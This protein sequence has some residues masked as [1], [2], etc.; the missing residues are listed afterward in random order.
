[1]RVV[2]TR[3]FETRLEE[4]T[5]YVQERNPQAA[6]RVFLAILKSARSL[7]DQPRR[8]R[9]VPELGADDIREL[10]V[11]KSFRVIYRVID[12]DDVVQVLTVRHARRLLDLNELEN[13]DES[14]QP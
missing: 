9:C 6:R 10:I 3:L 11:M 4:V 5:V 13:P 1:M 7:V 12:S 2:L 14:G 8:G